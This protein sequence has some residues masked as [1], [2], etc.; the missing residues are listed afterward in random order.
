MPRQNHNLGTN[1]KSSDFKEKQDWTCPIILFFC[2]FKV[3][4]TR[5]KIVTTLISN[6]Q[7]TT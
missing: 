7:A 1:T 5:N 2:E 3:Y 6:L 4:K